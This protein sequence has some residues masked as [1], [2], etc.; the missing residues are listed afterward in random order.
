MTCRDTDPLP[1]IRSVLFTLF[2][3]VKIFLL[4]SFTVEGKMS[5]FNLSCTK[6]LKNARMFKKI[7]TGSKKPLLRRI[8]QETLCGF[9]LK[10]SYS[11]AFTSPRVYN[12]SRYD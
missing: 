8:W 7:A 6:H 1:S 9:F 2:H 4:I 5:L 10:Q 3:E 11:H 12:I